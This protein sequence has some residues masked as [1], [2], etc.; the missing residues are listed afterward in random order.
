MILKGI[1]CRVLVATTFIVF[2]NIFLVSFG[3]HQSPGINFNSSGGKEY[4]MV[5]LNDIYIFSVYTPEQLV[6]KYT[7]V[8]FLM[9]CSS[10]FLIVG[11]NQYIYR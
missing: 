2:G 1:F 10:L 4:S 3:N 8:V 7:S 5:I 9:Y 6:A 11:I